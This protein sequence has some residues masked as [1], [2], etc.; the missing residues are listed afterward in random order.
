MRSRYHVSLGAVTFFG[1]SCNASQASERFPYIKRTRGDSGYKATTQRNSA[2]HQISSRSL[3]S[4]KRISFTA[5][6]C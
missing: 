2:R 4:V 5:L 3:A 6:L 1:A